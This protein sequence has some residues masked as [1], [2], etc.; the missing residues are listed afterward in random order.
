M[1]VDRALTIAHK[2]MSFD[3]V[4][5]SG[6]FPPVEVLNSFFRCGID[7]AASEVSLRWEPFALTESEY[8]VFH[9]ACQN[10]FGKLRIDGLRFEEFSDW[11]AAAALRNTNE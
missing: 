1:S 6:L 10:S 9:E 8:N 2:G 11:F 4:R 3:I 5:E 7:D